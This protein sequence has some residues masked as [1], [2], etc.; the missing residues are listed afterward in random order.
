SPESREAR[1]H[2]RIV[3]GQGRQHGNAPHPLGLLRARRE[4]PCHGRPAEQRDELATSHS[5]T[6]LAATS[7]FSGTVRPSAL[8]VLRL[9]V[10]SSFVG[11][12]TG[13]SS[14]LAPCKIRCTYH[15]PRLNKSGTIA[16]YAM[17][18][19]ARAS[20]LVWYIAGSRCFAM[21]SMI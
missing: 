3:L 10:S 9:I 1:R 20:S 8:A 13:S 14:G 4:R 5:I 21:K 16:P 2:F 19:P 15:A 17:K 11:C 18:P 12:S 7:S 6:S